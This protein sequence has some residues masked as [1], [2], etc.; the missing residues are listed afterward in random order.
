MKYV[1]ILGLEHSGTTLTDYLLSKLPN[2][3][4]LGEIASFLKP[5]HMQM[6]MNKWSSY[7]DVRLCSCG[8]DW[9][10]CNFW[11]Q[12]E[13]LNGLNSEI[14]MREKYQLLF[15]HAKNEYSENVVLIDSSKNL[16]Q[17]N[18]ILEQ[19]AY[20]GLYDSAIK[21]VFSIKSA[22]EFAMSIARKNS[23][24]SLFTVM[25]AFNWWFSI[26]KNMLE[27]CEKNKECVTL[28]TY[29]NLCDQP[30]KLLNVIA[31]ELGVNMQGDELLKSQSHSH[32][33][34]GNK[35]FALRNS[36]H[37]T[38]DD[39]WRSVWQIRFVNLFHFRARRLYKKINGL[40]S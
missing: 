9:S 21:I 36:H 16:D 25:Q 17:I 5:E 27:F 19:R 3:I 26:N 37:I 13:D 31:K 7:D 8:E 11:S 24:V 30:S 23:T 32:I 29:R 4:G 34:M 15:D 18:M 20:L 33:A 38:Y 35:N 10:D 1:Y 12:L 28:S 40:L 6:Y 2:A 14:D 39:R 22:E